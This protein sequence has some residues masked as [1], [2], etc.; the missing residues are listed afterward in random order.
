MNNI[1]VL[2]ILYFSCTL[3][4]GQTPQDSLATEVFAD[5]TT[6]SPENTEPTDPMYLYPRATFSADVL[7]G[8]W[9]RVGN[10]YG[11]DLSI[12]DNI[13]YYEKYFINTHCKIEETMMKYVFGVDSLVMHEFGPEEGA[14]KI[15]LWIKQL[16]TDSLIVQDAETFEI[17]RFIRAD[18]TLPEIIR[19]TNEL[20]FLRGVLDCEPDM[21]QMSSGSNPCIHLSE[22]N[23]D[24]KI[25]D[26]EEKFGH[27]IQYIESKE[28][29][30]IAK[31]LFNLQSYQGT[32]PQLIVT[33]NNSADQA[34]EIQIRGLG[35][36]EDLAF[37]AI[38]LGDYVTY[39]E[40]KLGK[41]AEISDDIQ[42]GIVKWSYKPYP[43]VFEFKNR[44]VNGIKIYKQ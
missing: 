44:Y 32:Q 40:K 39:V 43:V 17:E 27:T 23:L 13:Y 31:Y 15:V 36:E 24:L 8:K 35:A 41:P 3:L 34:L 11:A 2:F 14:Q 1:I 7:L 42:S 33:Y 37:S 5:A 6:L 19:P 38:H 21:S 12:D 4:Y 30:N 22:L 10:F 9:K 16:T 25:E 28:D 29:P 20:R 26:F 18:S